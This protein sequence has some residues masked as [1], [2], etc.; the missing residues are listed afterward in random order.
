MEERRSYSL[1][2]REISQ[3][4]R[5]GHINAW[6]VGAPAKTEQRNPTVKRIK[7]LKVGSEWQA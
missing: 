3:W 7:G 6:F 4:K 5:G 1:Q 2:E